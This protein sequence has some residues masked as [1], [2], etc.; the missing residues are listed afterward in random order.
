MKQLSNIALVLLLMFCSF[1]V[2]Y[3]AGEGKSSPASYSSRVDTFYIT[4]DS[5]IFVLDTIKEVKYKKYVEYVD[6][7]DNVRNLPSDSTIGFFLDYTS[8][9]N[10]GSA[11]ISDPLGK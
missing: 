1:C 10:S 6:R 2:G 4:R 9:H 3:N 8:R 11:D 7:R 5:L